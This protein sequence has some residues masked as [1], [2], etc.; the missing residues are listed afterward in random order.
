[1]MELITQIESQDFIG[2]GLVSEPKKSAEKLLAQRAHR[3]YAR[4]QQISV[5]CADNAMTLIAFPWG[6]GW[7]VWVP[8]EHL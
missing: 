5:S 8:A 7:R 1:M 6:W 2:T 3:L 4:A